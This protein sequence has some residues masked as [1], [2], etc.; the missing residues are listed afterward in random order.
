MRDWPVDNFHRITA[1]VTALQW[2]H[3]VAAVARQGGQWCD[4]LGEQSRE[5]PLD[6]LPRHIRSR[7]RRDQ[8]Y[9]SRLMLSGD[10]PTLIRFSVASAP[11]KRA[12]G[13]TRAPLTLMLYPTPN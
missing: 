11:K 13:S 8:P 4:V 1:V 3:G 9:A 12:A 10:R 2:T 7:G 5:L 6:W